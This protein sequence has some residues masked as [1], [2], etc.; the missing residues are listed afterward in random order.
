[1]AAVASMVWMTLLKIVDASNDT[2]S[3]KSEPSQ[4]SAAAAK[5]LPA[6]TASDG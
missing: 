4:I 3:T 6:F 2:P 1:M 5:I